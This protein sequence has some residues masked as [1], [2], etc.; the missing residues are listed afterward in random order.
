MADIIIHEVGPRDGLQIEKVTV[1]TE[2]KIAWIDALIRSGVDVVQ[3]GSFVHQQKVPQMAD[4]D[5]LF[6]HYALPEHKP[7]RT[8]SSR[9]ANRRRRDYR[10]CAARSP[11][12]RDR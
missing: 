6:A 10:P 1:P 7:A 12:V 11:P 4:T 5:A 2:Q 9:R 8:R 3:V